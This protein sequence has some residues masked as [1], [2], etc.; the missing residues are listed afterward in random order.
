MARRLQCI[1]SYLHQYHTASFTNAAH[2]R[3]LFTRTHLHKQMQ[4]KLLSSSTGCVRMSSSASYPTMS[5]GFSKK[6]FR[7]RNSGLKLIG[8]ASG[9]GVG[10]L[11]SAAWSV[12]QGS[13]NAVES[14]AIDPTTTESGWLPET[15][16]LCAKFQARVDAGELTLMRSTKTPLN[17]VVYSLSHPQKGAHF[18]YEIFYDE[19]TQKGY[20][21]IQFGPQTQGPPGY[22]H[23]GA[24]ATMFDTVTAV[25]VHKGLQKTCVTANLNMN[26]RRPIP[27]NSTVL[28]ET[29]VEKSEGRKHLLRCEMKSTDGQVLIE[30]TALWISVKNKTT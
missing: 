17:R 1:K 2:S 8:L 25:Y 9:I 4:K 21:V 18:E 14:I 15:E 26:F 16:E 6:L 7:G 27:L 19:A 22:V 24:S 12:R 29:W 10:M 13:T 3:C 30:G 28:A 20:A 11:A 5:N 23:G